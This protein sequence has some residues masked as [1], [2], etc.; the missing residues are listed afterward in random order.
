MNTTPE[1]ELEEEEGNRKEGGE[2]KGGGRREEGRREWERVVFKPT[3]AVLSHSRLYLNTCMAHCPRTVLS[4]LILSNA[5]R[6]K[7]P[8]RLRC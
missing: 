6:I 1:E 7:E 4:I 2:R 8:I 3:N 5:L